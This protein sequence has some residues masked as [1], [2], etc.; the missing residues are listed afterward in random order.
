MICPTVAAQADY[1]VAQIYDGLFVFS[2]GQGQ[3]VDLI[4][5]PPHGVERFPPSGADYR[6]RIAVVPAEII[7]V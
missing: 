3:A 6:D 1:V 2:V 5:W 7:G 4:L